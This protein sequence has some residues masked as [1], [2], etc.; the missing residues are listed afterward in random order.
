[1]RVLCG[2][3]GLQQRKELLTAGLMACDCHEPWETD[4]RWTVTVAEG[5][6]MRQYRGR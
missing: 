2:I 5:R 4:P 3:Q 1:M 6:W